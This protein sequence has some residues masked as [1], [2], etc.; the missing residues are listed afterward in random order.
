MK[1]APLMNMYGLT[2]LEWLRAAGLETENIDP[3]LVDELWVD[4]ME[5]VDPSEY[6]V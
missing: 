1:A 6:R 3:D 5:G 2:W 4:W